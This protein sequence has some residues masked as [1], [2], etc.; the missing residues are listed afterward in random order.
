MKEYYVYILASQ[1]NGTLYIGV[2]NDLMRRIYEHK[3]LH[4]KGFTK[5]Y[6]IDRLVYYQSVSDIHSAIKRE[7]VLKKWNRSWKIAL[8]EE[9]NPGW[10]D[11]F[12]KIM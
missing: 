3:Q 7:K 10:D 9:F 2:T 11:L 5:K 4:V 8:I 1:K 6:T 12:E